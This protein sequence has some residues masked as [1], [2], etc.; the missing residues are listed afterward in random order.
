MNSN[1]FRDYA[2]RDVFVYA[3]EASRKFSVV[4]MTGV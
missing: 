1:F 4:F 3:L 2:A